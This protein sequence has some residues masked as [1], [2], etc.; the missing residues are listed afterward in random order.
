MFY[1]SAVV[2][3]CPKNTYPFSGLPR[4]EIQKRQLGRHPRIPFTSFQLSVMEQ[5]FKETPYLSTEEVNAL[6]KKLQLAD[7]RVK[8]WFQNRRARERREKSNVDL[9]KPKEEGRSC[10]ENRLGSGPADEDNKVSRNKDYSQLDFSSSSSNNLSKVPQVNA[11]L[12]SNAVPLL[13]PYVHFVNSDNTE[14]EPYS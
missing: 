3:Q 4:K 2:A 7:I 12:M 11:Y 5:K 8:I 6:S 10:E 9:T 1:L 13:F 14:G